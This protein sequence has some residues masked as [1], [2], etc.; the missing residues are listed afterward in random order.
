[1]KEQVIKVDAKEFPIT[2]VVLGADGKETSYKMIA[3]R[4]MKGA[5][6]CKAN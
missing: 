2:V 4:R 5:Q 3:T 1:M 6:L